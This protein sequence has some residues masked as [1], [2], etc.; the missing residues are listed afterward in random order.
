ETRAGARGPGA[1]G[2]AEGKPGGRHPTRLDDEHDDGD[3]DRL[4]EEDRAALGGGEEERAHGLA[5]ELAV[6]RA[7]E[8]ERPREG[9]R[10][11]EDRARQVADRRH[12]LDEGEGADEDQHHREEDG[13]R[14]DLARAELDPQILPR[15]HRGVA[16]EPH[17]YR[18]FT[19]AGAPAAAPRS[20][21]PA[22]ENAR[23]APPPP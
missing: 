4:A 21:S 23:G 16:H 1:E 17:G 18:A 2:R 8:A 12:L 6:E 9:D 19:T 5:V 7:P 3:A 11:P 15:D 13:G 20:R 10:D 14:Q 22:P